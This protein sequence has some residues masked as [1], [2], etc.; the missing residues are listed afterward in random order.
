MT[1]RHAAEVVVPSSDGRAEND[2]TASE[3]DSAAAKKESITGAQAFREA[4]GMY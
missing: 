1:E 2:A 3:R 4:V